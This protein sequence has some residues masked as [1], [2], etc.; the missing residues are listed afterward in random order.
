MKSLCVFITV[1]LS[2]GVLAGEDIVGECR[3]IFTEK[4][5]GKDLVSC[6]KSN[7]GNIELETCTGILLAYSDAPKAVQGLQTSQLFD[8]SKA[9]CF[10]V[11]SKNCGEMEVSECIAKK[12]NLF[13]QNC[14]ELYFEINEQQKR[15]DSI[16]SSCFKKNLD[17]CNKTFDVP[18]NSYSAFTTSMKNVEGCISNKILASNECVKGLEE[19][20]KKRREEAE[21]AA[22]KEK[23]EEADS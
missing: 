15:L 10:D 2:F 9:N 4:C 17:S 19:K 1:I 7:M 11:I 20:A 3:H 6:M 14:R 23:E 18:L 8:S 13:P 16:G 21:A 12:G 22:A 5:D